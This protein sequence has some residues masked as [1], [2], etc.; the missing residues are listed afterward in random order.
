MILR[1]LQSK[2]LIHPPKWLVDN[3]MYLTIMGSNAYAVTSDNSDMDIYGFCIPPKEDVFPH[4]RGE[5]IGF[6]QQKKRFDVWQEHHIEPPNKKQSFDFS[7]YSIVKYFQLCMENNPNMIDSLYT[8]RN[9]VLHS[10]IIGEH[11][12][13]NRDIFLHKG[14]WHKF[15]GY[16]YAQMAKIKNKN[17]AKNPK[18]AESI[19][20]YGYD[21]K[22]AYHVVRLLN[23]IEQIL[24]EHTLDLTRNNEQLKSI[25]KGDWSLKQIEEYFNTKESALEKAYSESTLPY[26]PNEKAIKTLL[27]ECLEMHYQSLSNAIKIDVNVP[28]ILE[29][30]QQIINKYQ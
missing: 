3:V 29:E 27:L 20:K 18:R 11:V 19:L 28:V 7:V 2:N 21:V 5:I 22:F 8:P 24:T 17:N 26:K 13:S 12:R 16:A 4:L 23:E 15:K 10:T 6:G 25:R 30:M 9:C 14:A 1:K